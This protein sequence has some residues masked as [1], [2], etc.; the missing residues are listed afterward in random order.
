MTAVT[1][2]THHDNEVCWHIQ[3]SIARLMRVCLYVCVCEWAEQIVGPKTAPVSGLE[4][5]QRSV[6]MTAD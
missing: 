1:M 5:S 6:M 2:E 3:L 4:A